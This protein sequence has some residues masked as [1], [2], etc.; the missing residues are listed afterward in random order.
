MTIKEALDQITAIKNWNERHED[1]SAELVEACEMA[2][3]AFEIHLY[4]IVS[5][6]D[7]RYRDN[8]GFCNGRGFPAQLVADDGFCD[9]GKEATS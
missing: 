8:D 6:K 3:K 9:R 5:C 7:C 2:I 4:A 1:G